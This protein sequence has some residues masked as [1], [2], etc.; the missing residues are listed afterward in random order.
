MS[1]TLQTAIAFPVAFGTIALL[2]TAGPVLYSEASRSA[3]IHYDYLEKQTKNVLIYSQDHIT[4]DGR[5][6][7]V[8]LTSPERMHH[9]VRAISDTITLIGEGVEVFE[10][11]TSQK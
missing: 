4:C 5:D 10:K 2:L 9:L 11:D 8:A 3:Q 7:D 1:H 6:I